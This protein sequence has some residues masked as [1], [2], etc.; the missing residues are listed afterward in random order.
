MFDVEEKARFTASDL[1]ELPFDPP[2][3]PLSAWSLTSAVKGY[4]GGQ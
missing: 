2:F 1:G 4:K 3:E